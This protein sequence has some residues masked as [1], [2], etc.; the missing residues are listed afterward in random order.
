MPLWLGGCAGL[1]HPRRWASSPET[2]LPNG[3]PDLSGTYGTR[4]TDAYPA[5]AGRLPPL[6]EI[7]GPGGL[8]D[9]YKQGKPWPVLPSA[10]TASFTSER[11]WL[12]VRFC[13]DTR[14]A[15]TLR[16]KRKHWWGGAIEGADAM[17]SYQKLELGPALG[18]NG[19]RQ[20]SFALPYPAT[21]GDVSVVFLSKGQDGSLIVNYRTVHVDLV[22]G[23]GIFGSTPGSSWWRYPPVESTRGIRRGVKT[24]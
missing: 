21:K 13:D 7:L 11:N 8:S 4:A 20:P 19:A 2:I 9:V 1:H 15:A 12:Y 17:Y 22:P 10:T 14:R 6:N 23:I 3:C 16:F 5:N 18:I 24:A